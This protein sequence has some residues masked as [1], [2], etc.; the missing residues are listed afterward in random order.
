ME[1]TGPSVS[2]MIFLNRVQRE[3]PDLAITEILYTSRKEVWNVY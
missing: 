1:G 3:C 2:A